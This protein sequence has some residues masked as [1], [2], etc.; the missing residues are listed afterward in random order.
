MGRHQEAVG[1]AEVHGVAPVG[2]SRAQL[3]PP[4]RGRQHLR[5]HE[6]HRRLDEALAALPIEQRTVFVLADIHE[7]SYEDVSRVEGVQMGTVKSR[8]NRARQKLRALLSEE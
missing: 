2:D 7:L 3:L 1:D 4:A 6:G 8:L 5:L